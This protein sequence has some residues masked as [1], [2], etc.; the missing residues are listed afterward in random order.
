[1]QLPFQ[2]S[3]NFNFFGRLFELGL[4]PEARF[5]SRFPERVACEFI[6][7]MTLSAW[8][9]AVRE[10]TGLGGS[11]DQHAFVLCHRSKF[12]KL[13]DFRKAGSSGKHART[14]PVWGW[15]DRARF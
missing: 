9:T 8:S 15:E 3:V 12:R 2:D 6:R 14:L 11:R 7:P 13:G 10:L 1:M 5:N 4:T